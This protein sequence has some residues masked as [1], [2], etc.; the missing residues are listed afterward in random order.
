MKGGRRL[1][2]QLQLYFNQVKEQ[3]GLSR[4]RLERY[5]FDRKIN[6]FQDTEYT[7]IMEWFPKHLKSRRDFD[8]NPAGTAVI[9]I[10]IHDWKIK[11]VIFVRGKTFAEGGVIF[12][13]TGEE[14]IIRWIEQETGF[15]YGKHFQLKKMKG[16]SYQFY[17]CVDGIPT[18]P[19]GEI[20]IE[21][22]RTGKLTYFTVSG[23]FPDGSRVKKEPFRLSL[24]LL[25]EHLQDQIKTVPI[26]SLEKKQ[27]HLIYGIEEIFITND[28]Q[29]II[30]LSHYNVGKP[31][32]KI[33]QIMEWEVPLEGGRL[34]RRE[35]FSQKEITAEQAFSGEPSPD[36]APITPEEQE[37]CKTAVLEFLRREYPSDRGRWILH[38]LYR[39]SGHI[40]A[41]LKTK[42]ESPGSFSRKLVIFIQPGTFQVLNYFDNR[43]LLE[44]YRPLRPP[45]PI[46][47]SRKEAYQKLLNEIQ[48]HPFY[49]YAFESGQY[50]LCG[51]LDCRY[52][53]DATT[54]E[55][56]DPDAL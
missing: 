51:K 41:E 46:L 8:L 4:Y 42:A 35:I 56:I 5:W 25:R 31:V 44:M 43:P 1:E 26:P 37:A 40:L 10:G 52:G 11:S 38:H 36:V 9:E 7:L 15:T 49:V 39:E 48:L 22:D 17:E 45:G 27:W 50:V 47:V 12:P 21:V 23:Q 16:G 54:G 29:K 18:Y 24:D 33:D 53:V 34:E 32:A 30:P 2:N 55:V 19:G 14:A 28:Q 3:F 6:I 20:E 13:D